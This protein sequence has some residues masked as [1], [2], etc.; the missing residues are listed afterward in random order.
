MIDI[1]Q[2]IGEMPWHAVLTPTA[3]GWEYAVGNRIRLVIWHNEM[4][5][6]YGISADRISADGTH[7]TLFGLV[8]IHESRIGAFIRDLTVGLT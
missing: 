4:A 1:K 8:M 7:K 3:V 5:E 6:K 2:A